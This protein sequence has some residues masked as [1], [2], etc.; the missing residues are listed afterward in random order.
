MTDVQ[1]I[2]PIEDF[3]IGFDAAFQPFVAFTNYDD[4]AKLSTIP[5]G[6]N[7]LIAHI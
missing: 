2:G 1:V 7:E 4:L 5:V 3:R 6:F